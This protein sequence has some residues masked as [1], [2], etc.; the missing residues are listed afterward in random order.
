MRTIGAIAVALNGKTADFER[1]FGIAEKTLVRFSNRAQALGK[2]MTSLGRTMVMGFTLPI[3]AGMAAAVKALG[4][5]EQAMVEVEK[6]TDAKTALELGKAIKKM[7][8]IIPLTRDE[9]AGMT[10]DAA[11]FGITGIENIKSFTESVAKMTIA[12]DLSADE[13]GTAFA[14]IATLTRLPIPQ[15]QNLGSAINEL[16]NTFATSSS[17]I[18]DSML[19]SS[20]SLARL[21]LSVTEMTGLSAA[22]N[23][24][25]ASSQRAGTRLRR[26]A[27]M[28]M[29]PEKIVQIADALDMTVKEFKTLRD[30][31]PIQAIRK[32]IQLF[33]KG[34]DAAGRLSTVL[35]NAATQAIAPLA[36]NIE[37]LDRALTTAEKA[38]RENISLEK[39]FAAAIRTLWSQ[40]K[41]VWSRIKNV[42]DSIA[43][44]LVPHI[45]KAITS[46]ESAVAWFSKL[47]EAQQKNIFK[48]A[49]LLAALG[50]VLLIAGK[51]L[52][53]IGLLT[54]AFKFLAIK[55]LIPATIK[56]I[57][58]SVTLATATGRMHALTLA[59][60]GMQV[61]ALGLGA[62]WVGWQLGTLIR[63]NKLV[64]ESMDSIAEGALM[65]VGAF[66][67]EDQALK[68]KLINLEKELAVMFKLQEARKKLAAITAAADIAAAPRV[69]DEKTLK[70]RERLEKTITKLAQ[71]RAQAIFEELKGE[72][73]VSVLMAKRAR[74]EE[75]LS[76]ARALG[77]KVVEYGI[78]EK[79]LNLIDQIRS[80]QGIKGDE[81]NDKFSTAGAGGRYAAAVEKGTVEAYRTEL[82]QQKIL[83]KV[84]KNTKE[85]ADSTEKSVTLLEESRDFLMR[86]LEIEV[87]AI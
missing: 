11:R 58:F 63:K 5:F 22:L 6:V 30:E 42:A 55:A 9:L 70:A 69:V 65:M 27:E 81:G 15:I 29:Q 50:P 1:K 17:E 12:T 49:V 34:G 78:Q 37:E 2:R 39:E 60:S 84:E 56:M 75:E 51:L 4:D 40:L 61:V 38:F 79:I 28:M 52:T 86:N 66:T 18:V 82:G 80:L 26:V 44:L 45:K 8:E 76:T 21:G 85:S 57:A 62:F 67:H 53:V 32:M 14:K 72:Q 19:R 31:S 16:S 20:A 43:Q 7:A 35:G 83:N 68:T 41:L 33:V 73:K 3:V 77:R 23:A 24:V 13:A 47:T 87:V 48:W 54:T 46:V 64:R 36:M 10:A 25:S 59:I 74:L 71:N